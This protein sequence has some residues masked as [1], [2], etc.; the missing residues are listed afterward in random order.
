MWS[1]SEKWFQI[2]TMAKFENL[3]DYLTGLALARQSAKLPA[4]RGDFRGIRRRMGGV[5][6]GE[7]VLPRATPCGVAA[8]RAWP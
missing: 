1:G 4:K 3:L 6:H 2:A 7:E 8:A 5:C